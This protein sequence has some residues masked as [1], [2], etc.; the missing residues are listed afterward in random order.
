MA[1]SEVDICNR[2]LQKLGAKRITS[3]N[4]DSTNARSC[5][6]AYAIIRDAELR[7]HT[8]NFAIER[9][10]L[11][12]DATAP[13][14]GRANAYQ[15]PSDFLAMAEDYPEDNRNDKDWIIEGQ[16]ILSDDSDPI[17][18]RYVKRVT[19]TGTFDALFVEA[20][21]TKLALELCEEITQSN[22][23]KEG[24][25]ADYSEAIKTARRMNAIKQKPSAEPP[26]DSWL[27]VRS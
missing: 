21:A 11:A 19:D 1:V 25:R 10:E 2:A 24:L 3:L 23:K 6:A 7:A 17:Y 12:A 8:W 15:L 18:I 4:D 14:W 27:T 20:L 26:T 13:A 22:T 5:N 16:K 9:A